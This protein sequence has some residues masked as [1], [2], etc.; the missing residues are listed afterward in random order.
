MVRRRSSVLKAASAIRFGMAIRPLTIS[1]KSQTVP[2]FST[3]LST[4]VTACSSANDLR[5]SLPNRYCAHL[6]PYSPQPKTVAK[7]KQHSAAAM[8]TDTQPPQTASN[9][10]VVSTAPVSTP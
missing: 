5:T 8:N 1:L 6:A 7:A 4:T 10:R 3:A 9:A 2:V